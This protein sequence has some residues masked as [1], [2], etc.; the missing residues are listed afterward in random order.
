MEQTWVT[1]QEHLE[2]AHTFFMSVVAKLLPERH[3][4]P[5]VCG[6]WTPRQVVAHLTGWNAEATRG[7]GAFMAGDPEHFVQDVDAFNS[8]SVD[9]RSQLT[10]DETLL[11]L[12]TTHA[13]FQQAISALALAHPTS[14]GYLGWLKGRIEDY[15]IH[16]TQMQMWL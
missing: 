12:A 8:Q 14:P 7:F 5:G 6:V 2:K 4:Q 1:Q 16:T 13:S 15:E 3:D 9:Q 10:W 11:E